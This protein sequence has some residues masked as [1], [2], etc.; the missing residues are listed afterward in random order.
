MRGWRREGVVELDVAIVIIGQALGGEERAR[1]GT[2]L[3]KGEGQSSVGEVKA[4][5]T[6]RKTEVDKQKD[7][8]GKLVI[9]PHMISI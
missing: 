6:I 1:G 4:G 3:R 7:N 9:L 2:K 5:E 8:I